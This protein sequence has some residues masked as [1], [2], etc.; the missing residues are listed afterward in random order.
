MILTGMGVPSA[1]GAD[2]SAGERTFVSP[3]AA[4]RAP[5]R[6]DWGGVLVLRLFEMH[7][8][9]IAAVNGAAVGVGATLTL[10]CDVRP[11]VHDGSS[12]SSS[13]A[14]S[15]ITD[16]CAVVVPP[17][18]SWGPRPPCGVTC[19]GGLFAATEARDEGLVAAVHEPDDLL[20]AARE[21]ATEIATTMVG[22]SPSPS[23]GG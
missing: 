16:G 23:R 11:R 20:G 18:G 1:P 8:P 17:Q 15:I 22:R 9:L 4:R 5:P 12:G 7:K 6:R 14:R 10:P 13:P 19:R 21:L 2:L 3:R